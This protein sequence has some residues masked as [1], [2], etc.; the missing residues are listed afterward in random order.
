[1]KNFDQAFWIKFFRAILLGV[2]FCGFSANVLAAISV[3]GRVRVTQDNVNV[4]SAAAGGPVG[5]QD[6]G[7][8]GTVTAGPTNA[9]LGGQ[10]YVWW[11]VNFDSG[12]DG[13]VA[14]DFL[15]ENASAPSIT[16]VSPV[17]MQASA[18]AQTLT[19]NGTGFVNGATLT[20]DPPTGNNIPSSAA[21]LTFVSTSRITYQ[22]NN[23]NDVGTWS[24]RV[25]NPDGQN[26]G[27][28]DFE[29]VAVNAAPSI[30]SV[31]PASMAAS[32]A[33]QTLTINGSD[34]VNGASLVFDPP[35]GVNINSDPAKLTFVSTSKIT[36]Q[37]NNGNDS[38]AWAV[39][40][41]NPDGQNSAWS[42][43]N[44]VAST[45]APSISSVAPANVAA[46]AA[47][48]TL[49]INGSDFVN[50]ASLVFDPPTGVN[51]N[52]DPAKLTFV[53]TSKITYQLNNGNDSGGWAVRVVNPD[54][55]NSGWA[56]FTVVASTPAPSVSSVAPENMPASAANQTLTINGSN[57][58]NGASL[59]FDPPNGVN[60]NSDPAKLTFVSTSKITYQLN[61]GNDS[62]AWA[63][64]VV[65]PDGQNSAW[66]NFTVVASTPAPS[67]SSVAPASMPASAANQML[68]ING[69]NFVNGASL[70]FDP[71]T[72]VNRNS[73]PAKLTFV[74]NSK[75]T[76]QL[77]NDND[78]GV[79]AVRVVNPDGQFSEFRTF[80]VESAVVTPLPPVTIAPGTLA[81]TGEIT[82]S[83]NPTMTWEAVSGA[84]GYFLYIRD[85]TTNDLMEWSLPPSTSFPLP[86]NRLTAGHSFRWNM[87]SQTASGIS[88]ISS[89]R[90][91]QTQTAPVATKPAPPILLS[92][93]TEESPGGFITPLPT[94]AWQAVPGATGYGLYIKDIGSGNII[95]ENESIPANTTSL[96]IPAGKLKP[97]VKYRWNMR[98]KNALG[99][100]EYSIR[101]HFQVSA[102]APALELWG[103]PE[104]NPFNVPKS[105]TTVARNA[106][107]IIQALFSVWNRSDVASE[108]CEARIVIRKASTPFG[109]EGRVLKTIALPSILGSPF[110]PLPADCSFTIPADLAVGPYKVSIQIFPKS[111]ASPDA[112]N[113]E[114]D[115]WINDETDLSVNDVKVTPSAISPGESFTVNYTITNYGTTETPAIQA[116]VFLSKTKNFTG[117]NKIATFPV[118]MLSPG[119]SH[120]SPVT[121]TLESGTSQGGYFLSVKVPAS[122][123]ELVQ[124]GQ[125]NNVGNTEVSVK[126]LSKQSFL[127]FPVKGYTEKTAPIIAIFDHDRST[128]KVMPFTAKPTAASIKEDHIYVG[129]ESPDI[130]EYDDH[131]GID[132]DFGIGTEVRAA[133]TGIVRQAGWHIL[134]SGIV[135]NKKGVEGDPPITVAGEPTNKYYTRGYHIIL[136]HISPDGEKYHTYYLHLKENSIYPSVTVGKEVQQGVAIALSGATGTENKAH[137]HF[138]VHKIV[139]GETIAVDPYGWKGK[140]ETDPYLKSFPQIGEHITLW[141]SGKYV[142]QSDT[143]TITIAALI[144]GAGSI[145]KSARVLKRGGSSFAL[146]D[147]KPDSGSVFVGWSGDVETSSRRVTIALD[148]QNQLR[149][150][151][152]ELRTAAA[153]AGGKRVVNLVARFMANPFLDS[154]GR[155]DALVVD[156]GGQEQGALGLRLNKNGSFT[157]T[158]SHKGIVYKFSGVFGLDGRFETV[159]KKKGYPDLTVRL[160]LDVHTGAITGVVAS[161]AGEYSVNGKREEQAN[162]KNP[163]D[164]A[165]TY[166]VALFPDSSALP[167]GITHA[168]VSVSKSGTVKLTGKL[169]DGSPISIG[170]EVLEDGTFSFLKK[171]YGGKGRLT[172]RLGLNRVAGQGNVFGN[173]LWER[174]SPAQG[175]FSGRCSAI[176]SVYTPPTSDSPVFAELGVTTGNI[177]VLTSDPSGILGVQ[178]LLTMDSLGRC[179]DVNESDIS[180][181]VSLNTKTGLFTIT[182]KFADT[183]KVARGSGVVL[184]NHAIGAGVVAIDG[185]NRRLELKRTSAPN[186]VLAVSANEGT[187]ERNPSQTS[188]DAGMTVQLTATPAEGYAFDH[189]SGA[190]TGNLNPVSITMNGHRAVIAVFTPVT[191]GEIS[192]TG[193]ALPTSGGT[194]S[195]TGNFDNG[196]TVALTATPLSGYT[197]V[198]WSE[199]GVTVST[200]QNY[201]FTASYNRSLVANFSESTAP[202][203]GLLT[204]LSFDSN[205]ANDLSGNGNHGTAS[206]DV[207][208]LTGRNGL[209]AKFS[210][211]G[212]FVEM[213]P[214]TFLPTVTVS[215]FVKLDALPTTGN[216]MAIVDGF[217]GAEN[218][219]LYVH[220]VGGVTAFAAGFH[221][222]ASSTEVY[223]EQHIRSTTQPIVGTFYHVAMT[224]DEQTLKL[225][226]NG[227]LETSIQVAGDPYYSGP[228]QPNV[229]V[230]LGIFRDNNS[231]LNGTADE[232]RIYDRALTPSDILL[233]A[234]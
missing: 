72:G 123:R 140:P 51:I 58:V 208:F 110:E 103:A 194:I 34:F 137:L 202:T 26:S 9:V 136:E 170:T 50:G 52:S 220:N 196:A 29:V 13:W 22:I 43:F 195:G 151:P 191:V 227:Q 159:L 115:F 23:G 90:Y 36:Y 5:Q 206:G 204:Y 153:V 164:F 190:A 94:M 173:V 55:Q 129:D 39:R 47:N 76:Y 83:L 74:P 181:K 175:A 210:G 32:A 178:E 212:G 126:G 228:H 10:N 205:N 128:S 4:R 143:E 133:A 117:S 213:L 197:F 183:G 73:D 86:L 54:G 179:T 147:A 68:T 217:R 145:S 56:T 111:Q 163:S 152:G 38:G 98:A 46:S 121:L 174:K 139:N 66:A 182:S 188:Y 28:K 53:S 57:F 59:V 149:A 114:V 96:P 77:N 93:G 229:D 45:P 199:D 102:G 17:S 70:V 112:A 171:L 24:V 230:R 48:Q 118:P 234:Q 167:A 192:I 78:T 219:L 124:N 127:M 81:A 218:Y 67:I 99:F 172:G 156:G 155:I 18:N 12:T 82:P 35:T 157:V 3:G 8:T 31:A 79:W 116:E 14:Q 97:G 63:V 1:M 122:L 222:R 184:R 33:N 141:N 30:S 88:S 64:R 108:P 95:Y 193:S 44:V 161:E 189:W 131:R 40:V 132:Y 15:A 162:G 144:E 2:L 198:N 138:G 215:S 130:L 200:A 203:A 92:P 177:A 113:R 142:A 80:L 107:T 85:L 150:S 61:N 60:I 154:N 19:I 232:V 101:F 221:R 27:W 65:N 185:T 119:A 11:N 134:P 211:A 148:E 146:L 106:A 223:P 105:G 89:T 176:G 100:G 87:K 25:T 16:N 120:N 104:I 186:Y 69:S 209:G 216:L 233:L 84:T 109:S 225:Y 201:E 165:G 168:T 37:L 231:F 207:Q 214:K 160:D 226:I 180:T 62:G 135:T 125:S 187:V 7:A 224:F 20:F 6:T 42:N 166:T 75:I 71:P 49:T 21:K 169:G 158:L 91:F 41:K